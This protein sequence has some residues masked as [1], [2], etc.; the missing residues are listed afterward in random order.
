MRASL[1][2]CT[3]LALVIASP[4]AA[5][6]GK[7]GFYAGIVA[8]YSH[9]DFD[10]EA[11]P[12]GAGPNQFAQEYMHAGD[13]GIVGGYHFDLPRNFFLEAEA[14]A[15][16]SSGEV[17][18][19]LGSQLKIEKEGAYGLYLKPGYHLNDKWSTFLTLGA[20]WIEYTA[21]NAPAGYEE[22]DSSGGFLYGIGVDYKLDA[23]V[24]V[25]AEYNRVQ[26][27]DVKYEYVPGVTGSRFDPELDILKVAL[28]YHF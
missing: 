21:T 7:N 13:F 11:G 6:T 3:A 19:I 27:L 15:V 5:E 17:D 14:D 26:P 4:A 20:Q 12:V 24:S 2:T 23:D 9:T 16:V 18:T 1:L 10:I 22:T 8:G 25:S 28:K